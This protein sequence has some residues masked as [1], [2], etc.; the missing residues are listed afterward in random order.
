MTYHRFCNQ[1]ITTVATSC[2]DTAYP[3]WAP[4]FIPDLSGHHVRSLALCV[5]FVDRCLYFFNWP[6]CCYVLLWFTDSD[7]PFGIFKLFLYTMARLIFRKEGEKRIFVFRWKSNLLLW[8]IF[9][10]VSIFVDERIIA[11]WIRG[12]DTNH[13]VSLVFRGALSCLVC[14]DKQNQRKINT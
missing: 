7:Y 4:E 10:C 12:F 1:I 9:S 3:S 5:C 13:I 14:W 11:I 8:L 6:L 2:A